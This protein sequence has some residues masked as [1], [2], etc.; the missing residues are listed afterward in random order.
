MEV[1]AAALRAHDA[2]V[3]KVQLGYL[4]PVMG[5][6]VMTEAALRDRGTCCGNG[7]R[8]CPWSGKGPTRRTSEA[9]IGEKKEVY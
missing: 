1:S 7:C 6:F 5:L 9:L 3:A 2:A 4:D 8:H